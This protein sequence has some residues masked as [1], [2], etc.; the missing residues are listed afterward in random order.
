[1]ISGKIRHS[2][3]RPAGCIFTV[4]KGS[5]LHIFDEKLTAQ[6]QLDQRNPP[7]QGRIGDSD[8]I[9][10]TVLVDNGKVSTVDI[11]SLIPHSATVSSR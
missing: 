11:S 1:M 9:I 7:D 8:D 6:I 5:L 3:C 4:R 10:G 2:N